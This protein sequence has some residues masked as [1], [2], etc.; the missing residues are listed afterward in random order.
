MSGKRAALENLNVTASDLLYTVITSQEFDYFDSSR[1]A[2]AHADLEDIPRE[3]LT[4]I[5]S[6]YTRVPRR[7]SLNFEDDLAS[8][9]EI[10]GDPTPRTFLHSDRYKITLGR[11]HPNDGQQ[12]LV[13]LP[14]RPHHSCSIRLVSCDFVQFGLIP[15]Q[16]GEIDQ[17][18]SG[19]LDLKMGRNILFGDSTGEEEAQAIRDSSR[20]WESVLVIGQDAIHSYLLSLILTTQPND[21]PDSREQAF[22][23]AKTQFIDQVYL[24]GT[25][26]EMLDKLADS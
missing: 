16:V 3:E 4:S 11:T 24:A 1:D 5:E 23:A 14:M 8:A 21:S 15:R 13:A 17:A 9:V 26:D 20:D 25:Y 22:Q 7:Y 10:L 6:G 19:A 12:N 18:E 2:E